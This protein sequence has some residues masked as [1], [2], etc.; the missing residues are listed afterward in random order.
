MRVDHTAVRELNLPM[1]GAKRL[2]S[3]HLGSRISPPLIFFACLVINLIPMATVASAHVKWFVPCDV[4]DNPLP[5]S[6]VF[7]TTFWQ[8]SAAFITLLYLA[9]KVEQ[10]AL[11]VML[12][13]L[14]DRWTEPLRDRADDLLRAVAA[15]SF[16]LL[17]ADGALILTPELKANNV[18]LSAIQLL[19]PLF[20]FGRATLPAAG[21][22][23]IVLYG[24]GVATYGLFH[25]L[26][27]PVFLGLGAYF[28]LSVLQNAKL[29][30]FR[31]DLLRWTVA[32]SLL[33][34]SMEKFLYPAWIAPI[35][36]TH[37]EVTLG[38]DVATVVTAA[39]V[40]EFGL[41]FAL[42]WTPLIRRLAALALVLLL[43]AATFDFGKVDGI[44][45][46]MI[47]TIFLVVIADPGRQPARW[48]PA[49]APLVGGAA[50]LAIILLYT[51]SHTLS[52][53]SWRAAIAPL[54]TGAAL[55]AIIAYTLLRFA[56]RPLRPLIV[57]SPYGPRGEAGDVAAMQSRPPHRDLRRRPR[58]PVPEGQ[59]RR[60]PQRLR[61]V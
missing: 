1:L 22:G 40:V 56:R 59:S 16:A 53:E 20:L 51:G 45:H 60:G 32:F 13:T 36:L 58:D 42:F 38:F 39:G 3:R 27:Y 43:V 8:F 29:L 14:L 31:F 52:Y 11:G 49:L 54:A 41:T 34:P 23:I 15:V 2:G 7:T 50:W 5:L 30:A 12:S 19:I 26:D 9:C 61:H 25:M 28:A 37:P 18:G 48:R 55:L 21:A 35:V 47:I 6:A 57:E 10:T 4:A 46:L 44:G 24:Y 17:W 33:W